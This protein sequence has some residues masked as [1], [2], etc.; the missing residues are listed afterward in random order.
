MK[1]KWNNVSEKYINNRNNQIKES[2]IIKIEKWRRNQKY[3][4]NLENLKA[5]NLAENVKWYRN[6]KE[7]K[8]SGREMSWS[9]DEA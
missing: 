8:W 4:K 6:L 7:R 5:N 9:D 1:E 2:E 3:N